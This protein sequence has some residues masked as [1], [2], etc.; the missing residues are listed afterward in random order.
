MDSILVNYPQQIFN[1]ALYSLEEAKK[2]DKNKTPFEYWKYCTWSIVS[3]TISV[4][5]YLTDYLK[6]IKDDMG[7]QLSTIYESGTREQIRSKGIFFNIKFIELIT[8]NTI[9][10]N[11]DDDWNAISDAISLRNDLVHYRKIGIFNSIN[12][13]N[14]ENGIKACRDLIKKFHSAIGTN[15]PI[16][17]DK[18]QSESYD[19]P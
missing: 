5:S 16:W 9:I 12:D 17:V 15:Y 4:E 3:S 11:N 19:L 18:R 8:N 13:T 10:D 2:L 1:D 7:S 6:S 14:A